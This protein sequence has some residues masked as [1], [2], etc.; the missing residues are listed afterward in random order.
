M[1]DHYVETQQ[2]GWGGTIKNR[3]GGAL[4]GIIL[5]FAAFPL[6]WWNEGRLAQTSSSLDILARTVQTADIGHRDPA[7]DG[8]PVYLTGP[9][10]VTAPLRDPDFGIE[11][12]NSLR[13]YRRAEMFQWQEEKRTETRDTSGGGSETVTTYDYKKIWAPGQID[14]SHF[15]HADSYV[16]PGNPVIEQRWVAEDARLGVYAV[17]STWLEKLNGFEM[18]EPGPAWQPPAPFRRVGEWSYVAND[19]QNPAV[20]DVRLRFEH[21]PATTISLIGMVRGD[22]LV[23]WQGTNGPAIMLVS[24]GEKTSQNLIDERRNSEQI[25]AWV[26]RAVGF[27]MMA[28]GIQGVFVLL[29]ALGGIIPGLRMVAGVIGGFVGIILS[30]GFGTLTIGLA[31]V[32]ARP[33]V[34]GGL[35]AVAGL[36]GV[37]A[38]QM[39]KRPKGEPINQASGVKDSA[40]KRFD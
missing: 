28:I 5:F 23:A 14:S 12:R 1:S 38:W 6:L 39:R 3:A 36:L 15:R 10:Q 31:W 2:R 21:V 40:I 29:G 18:L 7:L 32:V 22:R 9:L 34:G 19:P 35:L 16:N 27:V 25:L 26:V 4:I 33:L 24:T 11:A 30:L 37:L 17:S 8:Q 13:L 20:G